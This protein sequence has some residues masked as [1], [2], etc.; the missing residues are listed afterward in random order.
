M[1]NVAS[2]ITGTHT[3]HSSRRGRR[4]GKLTATAGDV[5]RHVRQ[6]VADFR[7]HY[8]IDLLGPRPRLAAS[9]FWLYLGALPPQQG[10]WLLREL[11]IKGHAAKTDGGRTR[12]SLAARTVRS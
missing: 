5:R 1:D 6:V 7:A 11:E 8:R 4:F 2:G 10:F 9:M 3:V 12:R